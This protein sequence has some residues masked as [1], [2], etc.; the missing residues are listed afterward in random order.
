MSVIGLGYQGKTQLDLC[1][2]LAGNGVD[3]L[4]DVRLTPIS[5][6]PGLSKTALAG[7]ARDIG[8]DYRH[9]PALGNPRWN[10]AGFGGDDAALATAREN[11]AQLLAADP[12]ARRGLDEL[13][14]L[15]R[16]RTVALLCFEADETRCHRSVLLD[17][18]VG[19][20]AVLTR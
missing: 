6:K 17:Q 3:V 8:V 13:R 20:A 9:L 19:G 1:E 10:R 2:L 4:C 7:A 16:N 11:F 5:R 12:R 14:E 15:A 18:L